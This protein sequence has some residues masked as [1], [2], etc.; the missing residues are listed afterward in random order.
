MQPLG[1]A[2]TA[3][4]LSDCQGGG[5]EAASSTGRPFCLDES[6]FDIEDGGRVLDDDCNPEETAEDGGMALDR[7][8][9]V[10]NKGYSDFEHRGDWH[11]FVAL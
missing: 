2:P 6:Q 7:P 1:A 3:P 9:L 8:D 11:N 4:S 5:H 10:H